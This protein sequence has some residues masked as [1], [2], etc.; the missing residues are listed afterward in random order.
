MPNP[1]IGMIG[2]SLGSTAVQAN[3]AKKGAKAQASAA[4]SDI[5]LQREMYDKTAAN[6]EPYRAAGNDAMS[7]YLYEMGLG[8]KPTFGAKPLTIEE[9]ITGGTPAKTTTTYGQG[10]SEHGMMGGGGGSTTVAAVPGTTT[11]KV[12]GKTFANKEL[13]TAYAAENGAQGTEYGGYSVSPM[14]KYLLKEGV[15]SIE[16]SRAA[17][18]GLYSG[19]TLQ[20]MENNRADVIER[21]TGTY[22]D[23]LTGLVGGGQSAA[24]GQSQAGQYYATAAGNAG[25]TGANAAAQGYQGSANAISGG[26]GDMAGIYGYFQNQTANPM[27][28]YA[29]GMNARPAAN[30]YY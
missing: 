16:G 22:F 5:A 17:A 27:A 1:M 6:L 15:D 30:P 21:D 9:I 3:A 24:A 29:G 7:A 19:A 25:R 10:S 11:Y 13:A 23:R 8:P 14:A 18:G 4:A 2:A 12:G 28:S 20:A 26:I